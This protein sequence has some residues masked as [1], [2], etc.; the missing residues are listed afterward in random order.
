[1]MN[2]RL[3]VTVISLL[4]FLTYGCMSPSLSFLEKL[5]SE[6][7]QALLEKLHI[8]DLC[9]YY[10]DPELQQKTENIIVSLLEGRGVQSC[11]VEGVDKIVAD[12]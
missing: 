4:C 10:L 7:Q 3:S 2:K 6:Q 5:S 9:G 12:K 11:S 8:S 1:M